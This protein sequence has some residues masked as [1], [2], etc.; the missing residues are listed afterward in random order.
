M[1]EI[2]TILMREVKTRPSY[3]EIFEELKT[4]QELMSP[5][6]RPDFEIANLE[7]SIGSPVRG[8][9]RAQGFNFKKYEK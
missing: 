9:E 1:K 5:I 7:G 2:S 3:S 6:F 8:Q 4:K